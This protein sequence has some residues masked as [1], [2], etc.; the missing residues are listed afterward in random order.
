MC[1]KDGCVYE[2]H[3]QPQDGWFTN[4]CRKLNHSHG[5][6]RTYL[7]EFLFGGQEDPIVDLIVDES[8]TPKLVYTLSRSR[9]RHAIS[10]WSLGD[11]GLSMQFLAQNRN[12]NNDFASELRRS[13]SP[14]APPLFISC[15]SAIPRYESETVY[16]AAITDNGT[17]LF[18]TL[19]SFGFSL[20]W[21][22]RLKFIRLC[23]PAV[24]I[25]EKKQREQLP[26]YDA[27]SSPHRVSRAFY[28]NKVLLLAGTADQVPDTLLVCIMSKKTSTPSHSQLQESVESQ[29]ARGQYISAI[30]EVPL[31]FNPNAHL[32]QPKQSGMPLAGLDEL[33]TQHQLPPR[34]FICFS[35]T[36]I[37]Y[38]EKSRPR[39]ELYEL[40][41]RSPFPGQ[42]HGL[43]DFFVKYGDKEAFAMCLIIACSDPSQQLTGAST[44]FSPGPGVGLGALA[45]VD[46][47]AESVRQLAISALFNHVSRG[48]ATHL[49]EGLAL[50]MSRVLRP[51]WNWTLVIQ[52]QDGTY[53]LRYS[54]YQLLKILDPLLGLNSFLR[55]DRHTK[56]FENLLAPVGQGL[57]EKVLALRDLLRLSV[58]AVRLL[59]IIEVQSPRGITTLYSLSSI[60]LSLSYTYVIYT[61]S[62]YLT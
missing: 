60:D 34:Q 35:S 3:Y 37:Q 22:L 33:A 54:R 14:T 62:S 18:F 1:G 45:P 58:E 12:V 46:R 5:K 61:Y 55:S 20:R 40:L 21:T 15:L 9:G 11:D 44:H 32:Y 49:V 19:D 2:L 31:E 17:R 57:F 4:K 16:L 41:Q 28:S 7:P 6:M 53:R 8:R 25:D 56:E 36:G 24:H 47:Q 26:R 30:S 13:S 48:N 52:A 42:E 51:L 27:E 50:Y 39:D 43:H 38:Y 29:K 59:L 23:P 10:V